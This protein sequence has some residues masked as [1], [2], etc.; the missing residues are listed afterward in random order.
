M[1]KLFCINLYRNLVTWSGWS[2][3]VRFLA[4]V[5]KTNSIQ[6]NSS[7]SEICFQTNP[8]TFC[9]MNP[10]KNQSDLI[11]FISL[12]SKESIRMIPSQIE[13]ICAQI[14]LNRIFHL[15][16][17][18]IGIIRIENSVWIK[19]SDWY[20]RLKRNQSHQIGSISL[21]NFPKIFTK[22]KLTDIIYCLFLC[23]TN[24]QKDVL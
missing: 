23:F 18:E 1:K 8:K 6:N 11:Q 24:F 14:D 5:S 13:S 21:P 12:Q 7:H 3:S 9:L 17:F 19:I 16:K 15:N 10:V 22:N 20:V 4:K 2:M